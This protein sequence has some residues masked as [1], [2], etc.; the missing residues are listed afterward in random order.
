MGTLLFY[1]TI[2][3]FLS[4]VWW[5]FTCKG[6]VE[7]EC[8][9]EESLGSVIALQ[10]CKIAPWEG[11]M[12]CTSLQWDRAPSQGNLC[13]QLFPP[14]PNSFAFCSVFSKDFLVL[15]QQLP[16]P[17]LA[18]GLRPP[19]SAQNN[20]RSSLLGTSL[21]LPCTLS[22]TSS[23]LLKTPESLPNTQKKGEKTRV[24]CLYERSQRTTPSSQV[25]LRPQSSFS[26]P[27]LQAL[28]VFNPKRK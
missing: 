5:H 18:H 21:W 1:E 15:K 27:V 16:P 7:A 9:P 13:E 6:Q 24:L 2:V 11:T 20:S 23:P 4:L 10:L 17:T 8:G 26:S 12:P 14:L 28:L 19:G 25:S 22:S 3:D